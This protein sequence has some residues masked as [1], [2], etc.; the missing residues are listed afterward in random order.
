MLPP[1]LRFNGVSILRGAQ[2]VIRGLA[3]SIEAGEVVAMLGPSGAGKSSILLAAL[4]ELPISSGQLEVTG[5]AIPMFQDFNRMLLPWFSVRH[6]LQF[7]LGSASIDAVSCML[8]IDHLLARYPSEL[9]GG[10]RQRVVLGR[11]LLFDAAILLLDEPL[12]AV[13][14]PTRRRLLPRIRSCVKDRGVAAIWVT[15][16]PAEAALIGDRV[17]YLR[18]ATGLELVV[19]DMSPLWMLEV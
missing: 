6:N 9:S 12:S 3:L 13:D 17:F 18:S 14:L 8:E 16:F 10:E 5:R 7:G 15:H 19:P 4:G 1:V 11:A 2:E